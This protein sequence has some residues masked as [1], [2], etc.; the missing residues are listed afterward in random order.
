MTEVRLLTLP[1]REPLF[2][3]LRRCFYF[4]AFLHYFGFLSTVSDYLTTSGHSR[5]SRSEFFKWQCSRRY[6][7]PKSPWLKNLPLRKEKKKHSPQNS[8]FPVSNHR[9]VGGNET[10][11]LP[12]FKKK[13]T[14][15]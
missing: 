5:P 13:V 14:V 15:I 11:T 1:L 6:Y 12:H 7:S 4:C 9:D 10:L 3:L 2:H 8:W